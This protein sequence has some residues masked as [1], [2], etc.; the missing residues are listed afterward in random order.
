MLAEGLAKAGNTV[1]VITFGDEHIVESINGVTIIRIKQRNIYSSYVDKKRSKLLKI[2]W[3]LIDSFNPFYFFSL[4]DI[5]KRIRPD[6]VH[7][8]NI[9]GFS[10][11][12]WAIIKA[13]KIPLVHTFRDYYILCH[14]C[15]L[16]NN[17][18]TC[19]KICSDCKVTS[20][21]K[22]KFLSY[23]DSFVGIS[24]YVLNKHAPVIGGD[25][26]KT[27]IYN[28]VDIKAYTQPE[29]YNNKISFGYMGRLTPDKGIEYLLTEL[30]NCDVEILTKFK[31]TIAGRGDV[32]YIKHLKKLAGDV[33]IEFA[34][35]ISPD[36]FYNGLDVLIVPSLWLEPFGRTVIEALAHK[37]PVCLSENGGLKELHDNQCTWLFKTEKNY[38]RILIQQIV[39]DRQSI[40]RKKI[41][42]L[43]VAKKFDQGFYIDNYQNIYQHLLTDKPVLVKDTKKL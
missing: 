37:V 2:F 36:V 30:A 14:K 17:H 13:Q 21:I 23:P 24:D 28:G 8:N 32:E 42:C 22:Q 41:N 33:D 6:V 7:T 35:V 4:P 40:E 38:L 5:I 15:N 31:L 3:H 18:H 19:D 1:Y 39:N 26:F 34:G 10:P 29:V 16:F 20:A 43:A 12:I 25:K 9:L 27:V 11:N